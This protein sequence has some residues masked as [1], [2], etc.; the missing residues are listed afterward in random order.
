MVLCISLQSLC[1]CVFTCGMIVAQVLHACVGVLRGCIR[2]CLWL[3]GGY[4]R[5]CACVFEGNV[6]W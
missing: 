5:V 6:V 3:L 1:L 4:V 2:T